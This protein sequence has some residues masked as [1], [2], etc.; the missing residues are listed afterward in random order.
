MPPI[1][2]NKAIYS[3]VLM[4]AHAILLDDQEGLHK[5]PG[6]YRRGGGSLLGAFALL[7]QSIWRKGCINGNNI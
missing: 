5:H 7:K 6:E 4:S 1:G 2:P 3:N